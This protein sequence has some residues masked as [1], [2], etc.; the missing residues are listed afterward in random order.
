M[1][2]P[3]P[4]HGRS[5]LFRG[6]ACLALSLTAALAA[7]CGLA[8][9]E[10]TPTPVPAPVPLTALA[11]IVETNSL[12]ARVAGTLDTAGQVYVEYWAPGIDRLRTPAVSSDGTD[13]SIPVVRL[14]PATEYSYIALGTNP[15]GEVSLGPIGKF[16]TG[17]LPQ[18]IGRGDVRR[19]RRSPQP[20]T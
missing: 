2:A 15:E 5:A 7:A 10:P 3:S 13:F 18:G 16:V 1:R 20:M 8:S 11:S 12:I 6:I 17:E 19:P 9:E 14:R 4:V